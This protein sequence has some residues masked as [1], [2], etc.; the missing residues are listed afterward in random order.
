[1]ISGAFR[2]VIDL[3]HIERQSRRIHGRRQVVITLVAN[4]RSSITVAKKLTK[5]RPREL[6][7]YPGAATQ[8]AQGSGKLTTDQS[9]VEPAHTKGQALPR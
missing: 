4:N 5:V 1:M 6:G 9:A 2:K 3:P 8:L 7:Y